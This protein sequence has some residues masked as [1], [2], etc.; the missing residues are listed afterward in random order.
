[1]GKDPEYWGPEMKKPAI[2][3]SWYEKR[4]LVKGFSRIKKYPSGSK[5]KTTGTQTIELENI[6][7]LP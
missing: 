1:M 7:H 4:S 5:Q 6:F 3:R 2:L